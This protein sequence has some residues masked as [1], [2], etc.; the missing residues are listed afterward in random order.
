MNV[1]T[2][3]RCWVFLH[4]AIMYSILVKFLALAFI[5]VIGGVLCKEEW[6]RQSQTDGSGSLC[7]PFNSMNVVSV[8]AEVTLT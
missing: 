3:M 6:K 2:V 4:T 8:H 5:C 1:I 7:T